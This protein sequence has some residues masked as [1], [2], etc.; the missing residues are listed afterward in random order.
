M[1]TQCGPVDIKLY[2]VPCPVMDNI[3]SI[4]GGKWTLMAQQHSNYNKNTKDFINIQNTIKNILVCF[5]VNLPR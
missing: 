1:S 3:K 4:Y 2:T 5:Q